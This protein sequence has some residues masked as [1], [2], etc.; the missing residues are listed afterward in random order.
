M[1]LLAVVAMAD[2]AHVGHRARL[3]PARGAL[4]P[5][6]TNRLPV[7]RVVVVALAFALLALVDLVVA[8]PWIAGLR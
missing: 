2:E 8:L 1:I 4:V 3:A 7:R 5:V 6:K